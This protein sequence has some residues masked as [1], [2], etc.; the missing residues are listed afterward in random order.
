MATITR[1]GAGWYVQV[2]RKGYPARFQTFS[3]KRKAAAWAAEQEA[4]LQGLEP[5]AATEDDGRTAPEA[6]PCQLIPTKRSPDS[7]SCRL[8]KMLSAS[9]S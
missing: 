4:A 7:E 5:N 8:S 6:I 9:I 2:R 3:T 1:R